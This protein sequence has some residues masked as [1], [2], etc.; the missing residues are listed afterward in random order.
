MKEDFLDFSLSYADHAYCNAEL[1]APERS[2][3][4]ILEVG[5]EEEIQEDVALFEDIDNS[6]AVGTD[7]TSLTS[8]KATR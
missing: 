7:E 5:N 3:G 6:A 4:G 1:E 8:M 2:V